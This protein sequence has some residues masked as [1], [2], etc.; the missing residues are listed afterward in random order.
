MK[1]EQSRESLVELAPALMSFIVQAVPGRGRGQGG[2]ELE[3][4]VAPVEARRASTQRRAAD[5]RP[6]HRTT[7]VLGA[8][9]AAPGW[10]NREVADAAGL[11]GRR[12]RPR[13]CWRGLQRHGL[14]ENVG[15]GAARGEPNA[16]LLTPVRAIAPSSCSVESFGERAPRAQRCVLERHAGGRLGG[17][18]SSRPTAPRKLFGRRRRAMVCE[19]RR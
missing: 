16:W 12:A 5:S 14:I 8:I 3:R 7:L 18:A 10:S 19:R 9:G 15:I 11:V 6:T 17:M 13:S 1:A 4:P 2:A